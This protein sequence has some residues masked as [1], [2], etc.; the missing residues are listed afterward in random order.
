MN[1]AVVTNNQTH[2]KYFASEINKLFK[3]ELVIVIQYPDAESKILEK[4][5]NYGFLWVVLKVFGKVYEKFSQ[6]SFKNLLYKEYNIQFPGQ[7]F[8][9]IT[10][11][12]IFYKKT[13]N[14]A[15][16]IRLIKDREIDIVIFL[17]GDIAKSDFIKAPKLACLNIHSGISPFYNGAGSAAWVLADFRPNFSGVTLMKMNERIDGGNVIS[18]YLPSIESGDNAAK[19]FLK[20]IKGAVQMVKKEI[21]NYRRDIQFKGIHQKRSIKYT[22]G[23]DWNIYHDLRVNRFY[24]LNLM[25]KYLRE[26]EMYYY[27]SEKDLE[28]KFPFSNILSDMLLMK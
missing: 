8:T 4:I 24:K 25:T 17:G 28:S 18:H 10:E 22:R 1:I 16:S 13:I 2:H 9:E 26:K 3:L 7:G 15:E 14:D 5:N 23:M 20:G 19:L 21:E 11:N 12:R 6:N 27:Y